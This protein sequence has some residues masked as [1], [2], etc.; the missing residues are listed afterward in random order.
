MVWIHTFDSKNLIAKTAEDKSELS[1]LAGCYSGRT[2]NLAL[3]L[4][5]FSVTYG[6]EYSEWLENK[7]NLVTAVRIKS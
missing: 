4:G 7:N 2:V 5:F 1:I 6:L 3:T